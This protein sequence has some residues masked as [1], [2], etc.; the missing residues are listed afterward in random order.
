[1]SDHNTCTQ[2]QIIANLFEEPLETPVCEE[3]PVCVPDQ[4]RQ[5]NFAYETLPYLKDAQFLKFE[6]SGRSDGL[7][8]QVYALCQEILH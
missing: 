3:P 5:H 4:L 8:K 6:G 1:M 2:R 7:A